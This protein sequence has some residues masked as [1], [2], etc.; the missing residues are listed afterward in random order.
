MAI[1][2]DPRKITGMPELVAVDGTEII[3]VVKEVETNGVIEAVNFRAPVSILFGPPGG[4]GEDGNSAYELALLNG[5]QGTIT[6]WLISLKGNPGTPGVDGDPGVDGASAYE[7]AVANGFQGT[8][9]EWLQSLVGADG[10]SAYEIAVLNG[11]QGTEVEWLLSLVGSSGT[12][13]GGNM[14]VGKISILNNGVNSNITITG[15][16]TQE[17]VDSITATVIVGPA[18]RIILTVPPT[19]FMSKVSIH[20]G[21][22]FNPTPGFELLYPEPF[23]DTDP[24]NMTIPT[25]T[26][27][28]FADP[29][30]VQ[31]GT[32]QYFSIEGPDVVVGKS[33]LVANTSY[34]WVFDIT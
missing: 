12:T 24:L 3:E 23:G 10:N 17:D 4:D 25:L 16:G 5:F 11:F 14:V 32:N 8:V 1:N 33:G 27:F 26:M 18:L 6:D 28:N 9:V 34:R 29:S 13:T 30:V 19:F 22:G 21:P 7:I 15:I 2:T 31:P 20:Y